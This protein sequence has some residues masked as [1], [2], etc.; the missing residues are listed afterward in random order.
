MSLSFELDAELRSDKGKGAS[1]RLR[2]AGRLPAILYGGSEPPMPL[3]LDHDKVLH[4]LDYEA[5][6]SH[7]LKVK[8]DGQTHSCVLR[9]LQRHPYKPTLVHVDLQRVSGDDTIHMLIP[10]HVVG[11]EASPGL[12]AGGLL[13]H[14][15]TEVDITCKAKDLPEYIEVDISGLGL[16]EAIHLSDLKLPAGAQ[17]T[18]LLKGEEHDLPVVTI[19]P[20]K[21][22]GEEEEAEGEAAE[23]EGEA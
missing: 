22:G 14:E 16:N 5:F 17:V 8:V 1:R 2:R 11:Q 21:G 23:G 6:Y 18:E 15:L 4:S 20:R 13:T 12:K 10:L 3:T 19:H 9:D 7:I